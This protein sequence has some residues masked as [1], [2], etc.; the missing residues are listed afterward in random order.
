MPYTSD[1]PRTS[2]S[3][4]GGSPRRSGGRPGGPRRSGRPRP[5]A[6]PN[7]LEQALTAAAEAPAPED[8]SFAELGIPAKLVTALAGE[9]MEKPF[10]IQTRVLPDALA[11]R[12]VLGRAQTGSGKTLA[13]GIPVLARLAAE[14]KQRVASTPRAIILVPTR[15]LAR[16]VNEA[17]NPLSRPLGLRVTTVVGGLSISRQ[18]DAL[19]RGVDVVVATP[20]RLIDL[21]DRRAADLSQVEISVLDEADH[22]ADLGF[23]PAV[24]RILDATPADTQR[25]LLSATLD[26][27]VDKLVTEYLTEPAFHAVKQTTDA[28]TAMDHK[29]FSLSGPAEKLLVASE[30]AVRP[31]RTIF[32]VRTKHGADRL[33]RQ[34]SRAGAEATAIHGN[35][36]QNQRQRALDAFAAGS[37]RVLVA[38]DVAARGIHVDDVDLVVHYDLPGDHKDY[39]HRS[40]RTARAGA[41][42]TVV[43]FAEP[44]QGREINRLHRDA[45]VE[46]TNDTVHPGHVLVREIAES[47]EEVV[48]RAIPQ[49]SERSHS[50]GGQRR[51]SGGGAGGG[52][53]RREGQPARSGS[54]FGGGFGN[55]GA[56]S[57][58]GRPSGSR[59]SRA[60][61]QPAS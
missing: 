24:R 43:A 35:L 50:G 42:G 7:P 15:E 57:G 33:A 52:A 20:G 36:N 28:A 53:G 2:G 16:Q 19:R 29:V 8:Q 60:P 48:V 30:I 9:G 4:F 39:L 59:P 46:A 40:G 21:M 10:A 23:L 13:F 18:M 3:R 58:G 56:R 12:D 17:L 38:T 37:P 51:R 47:G 22:M 49:R 25:L 45:K 54:G 26:G 27:G 11:K 6:G 5:P 44:G 14:P 55:G 41:R 32:F 34:L 31:A 61:R 1:R